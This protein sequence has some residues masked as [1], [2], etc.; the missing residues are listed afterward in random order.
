M[1]SSDLI[2]LQAQLLDFSLVERNKLLIQMQTYAVAILYTKKQ[3]NV[4]LM[5][6]SSAYDFEVGATSKCGEKAGA[7]VK[8]SV[9]YQC[10][11]V[12]SIRGWNYRPHMLEADFLSW[13]LAL[14]S[15]STY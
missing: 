12:G 15:I 10:R 11:G 8:L 13:L 2:P 14:V 6:L 9:V 3:K 5:S 7:C 1:G 4:D